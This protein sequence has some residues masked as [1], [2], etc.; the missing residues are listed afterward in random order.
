MNI[1]E[2]A[3]KIV[4]GVGAIFHLSMICALMLIPVGL[5]YHESQPERIAQREE[6]VE[7]NKAKEIANDVQEM[8]IAG[9][10]FVRTTVHRFGRDSYEVQ[11]IFDTDENG[12]Q[13]A[14]DCKDL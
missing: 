5:L 10:L 9:K 13:V 4:D 11:Q 1:S 2:I 12:N 14:I 6:A 8:C 3:E 7:R